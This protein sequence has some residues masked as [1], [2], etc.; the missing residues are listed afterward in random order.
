MDFLDRLS[1]VPS[2]LRE[3]DRWRDLIDLML[4][5]AEIVLL[6][7]LIAT[8]IGVSLGVLTY[9]HPPSARL[10][11]SITGTILTIPSLAL[12]VLFAPFLGLGYQ[13]TLVALVL[14][15]LMPIVRNTITGLRSVDAAVTESALGMGLSRTQRLRRIELPMAWPVIFT[16]IRVSTLVIMS[17]AAIAGLVNGPGLGQWIEVGLS[18]PTTARGFNHAMAGTL[19]VILLAFLIDGLYSLLFRLTTSK[20]LR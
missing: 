19:G 1:N 3:R 18:S 2:F 11:L 8:I 5:H 10:V 15:A 7:V 17:I 6:S 9:R 20:G 14:Y 12:F 13:P 4:E 16:G